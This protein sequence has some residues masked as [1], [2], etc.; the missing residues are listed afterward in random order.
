MMT[1]SEENLIS[2][3]I[4]VY[5]VSPY[6][7][8]CITSA[9]NQTL[10]NIEIILVNDC[11]PDPLDEKICKEYANLDSRIKY[12]AHNKNKGL[13]GARNTGLRNASSDYIWFIDSDDFIDT[14]ACE[15]LHK[16][17]KQT[18]PDIIAFSANSHTDGNLN[19]SDKSYYYYERHLN[20]IDRVFSGVDFMNAAII[21]DSFHS[22]A[23]LS[24]FKK[25]LFKSLKFRE[26]V[27]H[28]DNDLIPILFYNAKAVYCLK[29]APYYRLIRANS[30]TQRK[31]SNR[32]IGDKISAAQSLLQQL[33]TKNKKERQPLEKL[34]SILYSGAKQSYEKLDPKPKE[35]T[36]NFN[37]LRSIYD[38]EV[39]KENRINTDK[40]DD[41]K[42]RFAAAERELNNIK[43]SFFWSIWQNANKLFGRR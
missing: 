14:N 27:I 9:I 31:I 23:C 15:F 40:K 10:K 13:G 11:S 33:A 32:D 24:I 7:R 18:N 43:N 36:E 8:K 17:I 5:N 12:I 30:I 21:N 1:Q 3:I 35:L 37:K 4:P 39:S 2:I 28:E 22:S 26:N 20:I 19:M 29:Y 34:S 41:L 25:D 42:I 38:L 6:L 16:T